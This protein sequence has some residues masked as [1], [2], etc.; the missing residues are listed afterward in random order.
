MED[1]ELFDVKKEYEIII[2]R[3]VEKYGYN[4]DLEQ[5]L[6]RILP[7][8][9]KGRSY[10]DRRVFYEML[11][12][13]Q[14]VIVTSQEEL[15]RR[16]EE[17]FG[18]LN[19]H[20]VEEDSEKSVYNQLKPA[21]FYRRDPILDESGKL[22]GKKQAVFVQAIDTKGRLS[23]SEEERVKIFGTAIQVS[24][25]I[26][27]LGHAWAAQH[28]GLIQEEDGSVIS[29]VGTA[30]VKYEYSPIGD[31][32]YSCKE[33][34][35]KNMMIEEAMNTEQEEDS[36][37]RFLQVDSDKLNEL[38]NSG[39]LDRSNYQKLVLMIMRSAL[40]CGL[41]K[42]FETYRMY[43]D[44]ASESKIN[45]ALT[46]TE[47]HQKRG[48]NSEFTN[49]KI[50][51]IKILSQ[52]QEICDDG[53][54]RPIDDTQK[55]KINKRKQFVELCREDFLKDKSEMS[56]MECYDNLLT[57]F[58]DINAKNSCFDSKEFV[59][60]VKMLAP[61][62]NELLDQIEAVCLGRNL[63]EKSEEK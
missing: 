16:E 55:E 11:E 6:R 57:Q 42:D 60:V 36:L 12:E 48:E 62:A 51:L 45:N 8:M 50:Q 3:V 52:G 49:R 47:W 41:R 13:T 33:S 31:G 58:F 18:G 2:K 34:Y 15:K 1:I 59:K 21:G 25:L 46:Q 24:H 4:K 7:A 37:K 53:I 19:P 38:Y 32:K 20:I 35:P 14:I 44:R 23:S 5:T 9:L 28:N 61:E 10:Q 17:E 26:H 22:V 29:R 40:N 30:E 63:S 56:P 39:I 54:I 43:N 27:E